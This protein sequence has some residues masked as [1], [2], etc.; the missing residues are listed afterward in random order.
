M[1]SIYKRGNVW[2]VK[3]YRNGVP[4]RESSE[5]DKGPSRKTS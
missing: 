1:G 3:Y 4:I 2:W 5:S